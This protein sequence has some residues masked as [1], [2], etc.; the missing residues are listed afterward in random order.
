MT[1]MNCGRIAD[2]PNVPN[3]GIFNYK[4]FKWS[5]SKLSWVAVGLFK[6]FTKTREPSNSPRDLEDLQHALRL[7]IYFL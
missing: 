7:V 5:S 6:S 4:I 2:Y 3:I 1:F